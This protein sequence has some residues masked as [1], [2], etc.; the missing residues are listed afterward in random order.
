MTW[1]IRKTP[2]VWLVLNQTC[3]MLPHCRKV[4]NNITP[5]RCFTFCSGICGKIKNLMFVNQTCHTYQMIPV[6]PSQRLN[7]SLSTHSCWRGNL[8]YIDSQAPVSYLL[9]QRPSLLKQSVDLS[10]QMPNYIYPSH[11]PIPLTLTTSKGFL[12][13]TWQHLLMMTLSN[14]LLRKF[15]LLWNRCSFIRS[16]TS[17]YHPCQPRCFQKSLSSATNPNTTPLEEW[18]VRGYVLC[19][20]L[21]SAKHGV[22]WHGLQAVMCQDYT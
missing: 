10:W 22:T 5:S 19:T 3:Q 21:L 8:W 1:C 16:K 18:I 11:L 17:P 15:D 2:T 13:R 9:I 12:S 4:N 7:P 14:L 20:S 6:W